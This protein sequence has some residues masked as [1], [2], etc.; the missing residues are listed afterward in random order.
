MKGGWD[1]RLREQSPGAHGEEP[2]RQE[3]TGFGQCWLSHKKQQAAFDDYELEDKTIH[4]PVV[5]F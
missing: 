1:L 3:L 5:G 2:G 4:Q